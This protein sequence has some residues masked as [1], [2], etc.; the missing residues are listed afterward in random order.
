[1]EVGLPLGAPGLDFSVV[2]AGAT[3]SGEPGTHSQHHW[4]THSKCQLLQHDWSP[5]SLQQNNNHEHGVQGGRVYCSCTDW[6]LSALT[7]MD[8][9]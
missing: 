1:M 8:E 2:A 4:G 6:R 3:A 5:N 9:E 7:T